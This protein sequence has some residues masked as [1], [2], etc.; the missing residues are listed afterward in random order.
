MSL[1]TFD[2]M[3]DSFPRAVKLRSLGFSLTYVASLDRKKFVVRAANVS[4]GQAFSF[5]F[6]SYDSVYAWL[7]GQ[8]ERPAR[9]IRAFVDRPADEF[10]QDEIDNL[11]SKKS[12]SFG[13]FGRL[14]DVD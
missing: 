11:Y 3:S 1:T 12:Q 14:L 2:L 10:S 8:V 6:K 5:F 13:E 7:L 9:I 4:T